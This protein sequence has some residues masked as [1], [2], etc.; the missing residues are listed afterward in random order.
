[1]LSLNIHKA[2]W[3]PSSKTKHPQNAYVANSLKKA[4]VKSC[5]IMFYSFFLM[6]QVYQTDICKL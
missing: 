1:M 6:N 5:L 3:S 2:I 4:P